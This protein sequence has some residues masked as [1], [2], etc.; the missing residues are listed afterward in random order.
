[1]NNISIKNK[2][3]NNSIINNI[4]KSDIINNNGSVL[5]VKG[6]SYKTYTTNNY[7]PHIGYVEHNLYKKQDNITFNNTNKV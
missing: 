1:M 7:K 3:Q 6:Y 5:N 4:T 2:T